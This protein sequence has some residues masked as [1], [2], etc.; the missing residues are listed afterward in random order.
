MVVVVEDGRNIEWQVR[1]T[2]KENRVAVATGI[3]LTAS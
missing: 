3:S 1:R 2:F